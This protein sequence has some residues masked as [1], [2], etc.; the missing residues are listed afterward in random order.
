VREEIEGRWG[1]SEEMW[2]RWEEG[3]GETRS[4]GVGIDRA[5]VNSC[6]GGLKGN[7]AGLGCE[8]ELVGCSLFQK[9]K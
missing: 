7:W 5:R 8:L 4:R 6:L 9:Q 3:E 2:L 1:S